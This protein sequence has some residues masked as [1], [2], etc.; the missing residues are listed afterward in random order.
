MLEL[1]VVTECCTYGP[2]ATED[3]EV[4]QILDK[5]IGYGVS[6]IWL[7]QHAI[8]L[9]RAH[10]GIHSFVGFVANLRNKVSHVQPGSKC[11]KRGV[12]LADN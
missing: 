6:M 1:E 12:D 11:G 10:W 2:T 3:I 9:T 7:N 5:F 4:H 8:L